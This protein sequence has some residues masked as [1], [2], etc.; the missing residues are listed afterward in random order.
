M[1]KKL[2]F[3]IICLLTISFANAKKPPLTSI[4]KHNL[5]FQV[6]SIF[7]DATP[8]AWVTDTDMTTT[9]G[10]IY[11]LNGV[12]LIPGALKFRGDHAWTLPYN[13][14]GTSFPSGTAVVDANPITI[15]TAGKYDITFNSTT[16]V[17]SFIVSPVSFQVI[18]IF[19]DATPGAWVTDTDMTTTNGTTYTLKGV[20]L[21]SGA[22]KF[23][24]DHAWTLPY[25]WGGTNF[26]SGTAIVDASPINCTNCR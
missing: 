19:G 2:L 13:W 26:P 10:K 6:I 4:E 3:F 15:P 9:D 8:G 5:A 12:S 22:L 14:G 25:N 18:S 11:N 17:Y 21:V 20:N 1:K 7:G 16:G 24:G 23:R